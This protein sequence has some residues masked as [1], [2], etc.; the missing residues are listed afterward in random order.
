MTPPA[1]TAPR[2]LSRRE[3][4][5]MLTVIEDTEAMEGW[6]MSLGYQIL[7]AFAGSAWALLYSVA[8]IIF[9]LTR[10]WHYASG[11]ATFLMPF[12]AANITT[13][14]RDKWAKDG[15][16]FPDGSWPIPNKA[17]LRR[18]I[19]SFGRGNKSDE[20]VKAW[21]IK[22]ARALDALDMLPD[23]WRP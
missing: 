19:Q 4:R 9:A 15:L 20:R 13:A 1:R 2:K 21:I 18:A 10:G 6:P 7:I 5:R 16:A 14:Q 22:R 23:D 17:Y 3:V 8:I 11:V 12:A